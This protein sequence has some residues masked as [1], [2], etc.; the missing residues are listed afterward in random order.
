MHRYVLRHRQNDQKI[1]VVPGKRLVIIRMSDV[2]DNVN[3]ALGIL[4]MYS[5]RK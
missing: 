2:A 3:P 4:M 1:Y 5:G